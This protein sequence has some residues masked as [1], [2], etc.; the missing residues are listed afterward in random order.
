[1]AWSDPGASDKHF[2]HRY[3]GFYRRHLES[4][5]SVSLILEFGVFKG[6][7]IAWLRDLFPDAEIVGVD[8]LPPEPEWTA[9]SG[10]SYITADQ[11]DRAA[12][13]RILHSLNRRFDLVIDD[14]SHVPQHQ[15]NCLAETLHYLRSGGMYI[16]EDLHTSHPQHPYYKA[17]CQPGTPT[18]LHLLLLLE[19]FLAIG[20]TIQPKD[21]NVLSHPDMFSAND[22]ER[23]AAAIAEIDIYHRATLPLRC[24]ACGSYDFGPTSLRCRCG[25]DLDVVGPD[26]ISAILRTT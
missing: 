2:W 11:G 10:I 16:L 19:R 20:K 1:M 25:V 13:A 15:A 5:E 6:A 26:S 7:S 24:Y 8:I 3:S 4:L 12:V 21:S 23:L 17:H 9:G 22:V 18:S 14:G